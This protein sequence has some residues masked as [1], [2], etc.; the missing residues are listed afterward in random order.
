MKSIDYV[1]YSKVPVDTVMSI[2]EAGVL[3]DAVIDME[4]LLQGDAHD[5]VIIQI[6]DMVG[7]AQAAIEFMATNVDKTGEF[8]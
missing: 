7:M 5:D 1:K 4:Y 6:L 2:V 3:L 8:E